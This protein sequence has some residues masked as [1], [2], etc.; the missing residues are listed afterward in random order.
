MCDGDG[1]NEWPDEGDSNPPPSF[2]PPW[3]KCATRA[4][5]WAPELR[6]RAAAKS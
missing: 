1:E 4:V 3:G 6:C 5:P 2:L